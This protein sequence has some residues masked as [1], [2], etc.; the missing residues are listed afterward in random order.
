MLTSLVEP[1]PPHTGL[2]LRIYHHPRAE[3]NIGITDYGPV[4]RITK[5]SKQDSRDQKYKMNAFKSS[6]Q[7]L[8]FSLSLDFT[9]I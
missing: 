6:Y 9:C 8:S 1:N 3:M 2:K 4:R 5:T 7:N